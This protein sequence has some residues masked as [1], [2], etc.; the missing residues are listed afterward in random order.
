M[1]PTPQMNNLHQNLSKGSTCDLKKPSKITLDAKN[2]KFHKSQK[3]ARNVGLR[4][5]T[6]VNGPCRRCP[7]FF[8][9]LLRFHQR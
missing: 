8:A 5:S 7:S 4:N 2:I 1:P 3:K 6:E 9:G